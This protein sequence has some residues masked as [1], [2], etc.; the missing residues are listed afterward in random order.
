MDLISNPRRARRFARV[1]FSDVAFYAGEQLRIGIEKDDL[2]D[3]L[4]PELEQARMYYDHNVDS[5]L[6]DKQRIF[7][8]ALVDVLIYPM[9]GLPSHIW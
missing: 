4:A 1:I 3:R 9:R 5:S 8:H 7:N 2:L 6:P